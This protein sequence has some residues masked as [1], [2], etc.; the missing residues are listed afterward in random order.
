MYNLFIYFRWRRL[1]LWWWRYW[2]SSTKVRPK[3]VS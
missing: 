3:W 1:C 2:N